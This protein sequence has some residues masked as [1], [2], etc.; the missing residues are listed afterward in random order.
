MPI[1]G[2]D[3]DGKTSGMAVGATNLLLVF[4]PLLGWRSVLVTERR[5][6]QDFD[7]VL[8]SIQV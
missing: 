8:R 3:I 7:D 2:R 6:A 1:Y 4:E 5:T